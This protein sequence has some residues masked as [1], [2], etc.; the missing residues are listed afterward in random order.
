MVGEV[1]QMNARIDRRDQLET[2]LGRWI[3]MFE[4]RRVEESIQ[5]LYNDGYIRGSTHLAIG[6]EA[7]AVGIASVLRVT[8]TVTCTYRGHAI[9]LALGLTPEEVLGEICGRDIGCGGGVGGSM[10]LSGFDVGL[11]PT[12][13]I[14]GAGVPVAAGAALS[15]QTVGS[16]AVAVAVFGDGACNIGA[17]HE[18][19]NLASI[20][21]LPLV[22]VIEN[23]LYGEY[24][25][26]QS[27]TPIID[28]ARRAEGYGMPWKVVDGQDD[29]AVHQVV[30]EAV[31][32]A[33]TGD[34]PTV[35]EAKTYRYSGH[36]RSDPASYRPAGELDEWQAR[37]PIDI[38]ASRLT[39]YS[40]D[41]LKSS[42]EES[43]REA[44]AKV[45]ESPM[46]DISAAFA[47]VT[48]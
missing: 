1:S 42:V 43:L 25:S 40:L 47:H 10:H 23:N 41:E 39:S 26:I 2:P 45:L 8:D 36:S 44:I 32:R 29:A 16:D 5:Q 3:R 13:A 19:M 34:G 7:V 38:A 14:V 11:M 37:D 22:F 30:A 12:F 15:A 17:V 9:A 24:S 48:A 18:T 20:W 28:L 35:L 27:T 46:P 31:G 33:R 4:I 21:K 6:Q